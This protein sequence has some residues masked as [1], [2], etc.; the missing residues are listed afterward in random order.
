MS[1]GVARGA[2]FKIPRWVQHIVLNNFLDQDTYL[3]ATQQPHVLSAEIAAQQSNFPTTVT[4]AAA[5]TPATSFSTSASTASSSSSPSPQS[6]R[7]IRRQLYK[8][9]SPSER[10]LLQVGR[11]LDEAVPRMPGRYSAGS[12]LMFLNGV[13]PR[14]VVLDR[15]AQHTSICPD[16]QDVVRRSRRVGRV[17]WVAAAMGLLLSRSGSAAKAPLAAAAL[18]LGALGIAARR[19]LQEFHYIYDERRRN[20]DLI[21]I[22][23]KFADELLSL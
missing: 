15:W 16:S 4:T 6:R 2:P 3:L 23:A 13:P 20:F 8:Y 14:S 9:R 12:Q 5:I 18:M 19:L 1:A 11:F 7:L 22:P 21:K 10:L 17:T